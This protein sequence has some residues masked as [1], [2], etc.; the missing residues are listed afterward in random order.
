MF[1]EPTENDLMTYFY[2]LVSFVICCYPGNWYT[3]KKQ[4]KVHKHYNSVL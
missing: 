3:H 1:T 4:H 2:H